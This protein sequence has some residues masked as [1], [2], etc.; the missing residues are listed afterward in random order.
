MTVYSTWPSFR[1]QARDDGLASESVVVVEAGNSLLMFH[2]GPPAAGHAARALQFYSCSSF[3]PLGKPMHGQ[4]P[5]A[6]P[7]PPLRDGWLISILD[8]MVWGVI[9]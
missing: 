4:W 2:F 6:M 1:I 9:A 3:Q 7:S 8:V 5:L